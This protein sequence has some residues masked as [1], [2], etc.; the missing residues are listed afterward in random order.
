MSNGFFI[1]RPHRFV[2]DF[3]ENNETLSYHGRITY[4]EGGV[5]MTTVALFYD[6]VRTINEY[7][8][9]HMHGHVVDL[10]MRLTVQKR[11]FEPQVYDETK[12]Q[13]KRHTHI[14]SKARYDHV[15]SHALIARAHVEP[16]ITQL[17]DHVFMKVR[18][19]RDFPLAHN[20]SLYQAAIYYEREPYVNEER[21]RD[22]LH[23]LQQLTPYNAKPCVYQAA[24]LAKVPKPLSDIQKHVLATQTFLIERQFSPINAH[25][26]AVMAYVLSSNVKQ[27]AANVETFKVHLE[28]LTALRPI[29]ES[30]MW[31]IATKYDAWTAIEYYEQLEQQ[32]RRLPVNFSAQT[33][34]TLLALQLFS[35]TVLD[36]TETLYGGDVSNDILY[37]FTNACDDISKGDGLY[38]YSEGDSYVD[39]GDGE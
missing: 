27:T 26:T 34:V 29:Y 39:S 28:K 15:I 30:Y 35:A 32:L 14:L 5:H 1:R 31:I 18:Q 7:T 16:S 12:Q 22:I 36:H 33:D 11:M 21:L 37:D 8:K 2:N 24:A 9:W 25:I 4:I 3:S 13:I 20:A 19:L 17:I 23:F 38:I 6:N 10:A